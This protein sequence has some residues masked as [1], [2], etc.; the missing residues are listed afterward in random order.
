MDQLSNRL[1]VTENAVV[2]LLRIIGQADVPLERLP[3]K[4]SRF[5]V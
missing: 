5:A 2:E 3:E 4:L 1:K